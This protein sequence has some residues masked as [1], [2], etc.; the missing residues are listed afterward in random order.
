[1]VAIVLPTCLK[2]IPEG[3]TYLSVI[4][5][6]RIQDCIVE[7]AIAFIIDRI[8][9]PLTNIGDVT[10]QTEMQQWENVRAAAL[11]RRI[12]VCTRI[13]HLI[14]QLRDGDWKQN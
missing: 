13:L 10:F 6:V 12:E 2:K 11:E 8:I 1:V 14:H 4:R 7:V 5:N 9:V 3:L